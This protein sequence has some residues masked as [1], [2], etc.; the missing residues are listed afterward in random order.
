MYKNCD[1]M[2]TLKLDEIPEEGLCLKWEEERA[3]LFAYLEDLSKIDFDF[4]TPLQS[5]VKI[6]E[7]RSIGLNNRKGPNHSS[8]AV[9]KVFKRILLF[10]LHYL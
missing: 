1:E 2:F 3:S 9:C 8:I 6:K 10:S 7:G 5:E 4:E